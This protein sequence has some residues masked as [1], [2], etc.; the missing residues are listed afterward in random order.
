MISY[1]KFNR[2]AEKNILHNYF[3]KLNNFRSSFNDIVEGRNRRN[4]YRL[5]KKYGKNLLKKIS[6]KYR[7]FDSKIFNSVNL[8]KEDDF[9]KS[10]LRFLQL[11]DF[12]FEDTIWYS[13]KVIGFRNNMQGWKREPNNAYDPNFIPHL[14]ATAY[15]CI[16]PHLEAMGY[17][18][19][20][21]PR[22][23]THNDYVYSLDNHPLKRGKSAIDFV[24]ALLDYARQWMNTYLEREIDFFDDNRFNHVKYIEP[25]SQ[26]PQG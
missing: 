23:Y 25:I 18:T 5:Q 24:Q 7:S 11:P 16:P 26:Q 1:D 13:T 12:Y 10:L 4:I 9:S 21:P 2:T 3:I 20:V 17:I 22:E 6:D 8:S 15:E 14:F 19:V